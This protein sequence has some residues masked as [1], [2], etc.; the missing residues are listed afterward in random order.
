MTTC[1]I[2]FIDVCFPKRILEYTEKE[3]V[4]D[5]E[6]ALYLLRQQVHVCILQEIKEIETMSR[7]ID[8]LPNFPQPLL[9]MILSYFISALDQ[10][11]WIYLV[12]HC[13]HY[14]MEGKDLIHLLQVTGYLNH[15][16]SITRLCLF[17]LCIKIDLPSLTWIGHLWCRHGLVSCSLY[18]KDILGT[19]RLQ[20]F[21]AVLIRVLIRGGECQSVPPLRCEEIYSK[22]SR[23]LPYLGPYSI[24]A[25]TIEEES[26]FLDFEII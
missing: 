21:G 18:Q 11:S 23:L 7:E 12:Q 8:R 9:R 24:G 17:F 25:S 10:K 1:G 13:L 16:I 5:D 22:I 3:Q 19:K 4:P 2:E 14:Q 6:L 20:Y 15:S 26:S